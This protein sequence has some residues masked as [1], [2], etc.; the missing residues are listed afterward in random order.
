MKYTEPTEL[1]QLSASEANAV[2][3]AL[4][5]KCN[6]QQQK[7]M[8]LEYKYEELTKMIRKQGKDQ[9]RSEG[10]RFLSSYGSGGRKGPWN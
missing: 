1:E 3:I 5:N 2:L 7:I 8:E 4:Q 9:V 10:D 6:I